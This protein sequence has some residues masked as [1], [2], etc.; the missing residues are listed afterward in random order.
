MRAIISVSDKTGLAPFAQRLAQQ[1]VEIFSTGGTL[2]VLQQANVAAQSIS[3]LTNFSEILDG[4]VK[5]LHPAVH[6]GILH[7]REDPQ[8]RA[9]IGQHGIEAIDLVVVNLYP[10]AQTI[11]QPDVALNDALEQID[12][13]GPTLVR[14]AAKNFA[15]VLVVIDPA[16]YDA[17]LEAIEHSQIERNLRQRLAAKAFAHTAAY[18]S[19]I[20]AYLNTEQFP[21]TLPLAWHKAY[22][23][24]Y[25]ENP[26]QAAAFYRESSTTSGTIADT[27]LLQGKALSFNNL[28]DADAALQITRSFDA[29]TIAI[30]KHTNPCGLASHDDLVAAHTAARSGDP[31]SAFGGIVGINRPVDGRL[32]EAMQRYFYEVIIAPH[33]DD[34][35]RAIFA[36]K[37]N[38]RLMELPMDVPRGTLRW[39]YRRV[40]GGLLVQAA[41]SVHDDDPATWQ[42]VTQRAPTPEQ[43]NALQ[44][45]WKACAFVKSNA[46]VLVQKQTLVGMGAGQP[47][48]VDSVKIAASKAGDRAQGSVLASD[49]FF[50]K[51]DGVEAAAAA[52]VTA[53]V[54]PGGSQADNDVIAAAD[55]LGLAMVF[56]ERRHFKH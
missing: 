7:R 45:A 51:P 36:R 44:F 25:G 21:A 52:G 17:V 13:G 1:G 38:L 2:K 27:E 40:S 15:D 12:I 6:G 56:T 42:V 19:T 50:P 4:R 16:D 9:Q 14:A 8:H 10:F 34:G 48:R 30:I 31:V 26:H 18:D 46:I 11:A 29:P 47:S 22:D 43:M 37:T 49:A 20:A 41:D 35:A 24:R 53:I 28:L 23:L 54:Q 3:E 39:D 33:F 5:T 55:R 32:A